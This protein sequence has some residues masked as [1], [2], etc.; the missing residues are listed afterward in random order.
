MVNLFI[1]SFLRKLFI[2]H[3]YR[4]VLLKLWAP[5]VNGAHGLYFLVIYYQ[6]S[7]RV[8]GKIMKTKETSN[9]IS[10]SKSI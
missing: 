8:Y 2:F 1:Y 4:N 3:F 9:L 6:M 5:K 7:L 10:R